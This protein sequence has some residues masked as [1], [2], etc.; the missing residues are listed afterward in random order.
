MHLIK[1]N[2]SPPTLPALCDCP[3]LRRAD[4][5]RGDVRQRRPGSSHVTAGSSRFARAAHGGQRASS[6]R[7]PI[8][9]GLSV[10]RQR[11]S[12]GL[13]LM[14]LTRSCIHTLRFP[15][16]SSDKGRY[17]Y[18]DKNPG[19]GS[20]LQ[21]RETRRMSIGKQL[22]VV[23][24]LVLLPVGA[25]GQGHDFQI[26]QGSHVQLHQLFVDNAS[27]FGEL[28]ENLKARIQDNEVVVLFAENMP[29]R[30]HA[31]TV[32][33][34]NG[35]RAILLPNRRRNQTGL[36][37]L[38]AMHEQAHEDG[39]HLPEDP[40]VDPGTGEVETEA[41][42][43]TRAA[44]QEAEANCETL[45]VFHIYHQETGSKLSCLRYHQTRES[46]INSWERCFDEFYLGDPAPQ[47]GGG[48]YECTQPPYNTTKVCKS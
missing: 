25:S 12:P 47:P 34:E 29:P 22:G 15:C 44:C 18:S 19:Y 6:P 17:R 4:P 11:G 21:R 42:A 48:T 10:L 32:E 46:F 24:A 41:E 45:K 9:A 28:G 31:V 38:M 36:L 43:A 14:G 40:Q 7:S 39:G 5:N 35:N 27:K 8:G 2:S 16:D 13:G 1:T 3:W 26:V 20:G 23:L 33:D 30:A 37:I